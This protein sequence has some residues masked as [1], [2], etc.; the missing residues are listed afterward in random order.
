MKFLLFLL[1]FFSVPAQAQMLCDAMQKDKIYKG[2][3]KSYA[4]IIEG[5]DGWLFRS[6]TDFQTDFS[7][8]PNI[9]EI[10]VSLHKAFKSKNID[11]VIVPLPT[12]GMAQAEFIQ[13]Y[14]FDKKVARQSYNALIQDLVG[15]GMIV[16]AYQE[17]ASKENFFY[18]QDH[19]WRAEGAK[20]TAEIVAAKIK[21]LDVY[22]DL[23]KKTFS[24]EMVEKKSFKGRFAK[25]VEKHCKGVI[26]N[27]EIKT[28]KTYATDED[29]FGDGGTPEIILI[30][31]S[32]SDNEA[33]QANFEGFL[34]QSIGADIKNLSISG[35][36]FDSAMLQW[37]ASGEYA[38]QKPKILIWEF[39]MYKDFKNQDFYRQAIPAIYGACH[40][41]ALFSQDVEVLDN[42]FKVTLTEPVR[43]DY[44][45]FNLPDFNKDK[46]RVIFQYQDKSK[47]SVD[48]ERSKFYEADGKFFINLEKDKALSSFK[49]LLP[50]GEYT[51]GNMSVCHYSASE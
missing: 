36:G 50:D 46:L 33:S 4:K 7:I 8:K 1:L 28:Y 29:L 47:D 51:D 39:P 5:K 17:G 16:A 42:K 24:T 44:I 22:K 25:F 26:F 20:R 40:D 49:V 19:H 48:I 12:R 6:K 10:L 38:E 45:I 27:E 2:E 21:S 3:D 37:L 9:K 14:D 18:K 34:K 30:G 43:G 23:P 35:G 32:N 13:N 31:T 15:A 11:L 41:K